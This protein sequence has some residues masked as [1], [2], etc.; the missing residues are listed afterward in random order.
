MKNI[1]LAVLSVFLFVVLPMAEAVKR[2]DSYN[3]RRGNEELQ[4]N[5]LEGAWKFF[6]QEISENP[7]NGYAYGQC[8]YILNYVHR[9][10]D[11]Q[12]AVDKAIK[13]VPSKDKEAVSSL[14]FQRH[15]SSLGLGDTAQAIA[16]LT[17]GI[18]IYK[19]SVEDLVA[20]GDLY[21]KQK[22]YNLAQSD[23]NA[24][25]SAGAVML[26]NYELGVLSNDQ[27][28]WNDALNYLDLAKKN[29]DQEYTEIYFQQAVA[30]Y[31]LKKT[32]EAEDCMANSIKIRISSDMVEYVDKLDSSLQRSL[33]RHLDAEYAK[34]KNPNYSSMSAAFL[35]MSKDYAGAIRHYKANVT[36]EDASFEMRRISSCYLE[37]GMYN[38]ALE[39][40]DQVGNTDSA[41]IKTLNSKAAILREMGRPKEAVAALNQYIERFP[42]DAY[43]YFNRSSAYETF[44]RDSAVADLNTAIILDPKNSSAILHRGEVLVSLGRKDEAKEDFNTILAAK[45]DDRNL[46]WSKVFAYVNL[47]DSAKALQMSD[48]LLNAK[49]EGDDMHICYY[50]KACV[51]SCMGNTAKAIEYLRKD[52]ETGFRRL[53]YIEKDVDLDPIRNTVEYK[54]MMTDFRNRQM[55]EN[56]SMPEFDEEMAKIKEQNTPTHPVKTVLPPAVKKTNKK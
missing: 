43:G 47:G 29:A 34:D 12:M 26:G 23:F 33:S 53:G 2:P 19:K 54:T 40:L 45:D 24:A 44:M 3:Y 56:K 49:K 5:N 38:K 7:K 42:E 31:G 32:Q 11:A 14:Y 27:K 48:S 18:S 36:G 21:L 46:D 41:K 35:E 39:Y 20:R 16:D 13:L 1:R 22:K 30:N 51:Y 6:N 9:Y 55:E 52:F 28:K 8:A 17:K 15:T 10:G 25:I 50:N 4:D 37:C